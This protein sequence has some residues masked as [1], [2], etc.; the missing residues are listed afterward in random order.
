V[1]LDYARI[2]FLRQ[3]VPILVQEKGHIH[4]HHEVMC[5]VQFACDFLPVTSA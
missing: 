5:P 1:F 4:P 3:R 2:A